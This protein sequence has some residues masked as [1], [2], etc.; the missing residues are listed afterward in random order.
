MKLIRSFSRFSPLLLK[1]GIKFNLQAN[2]YVVPGIALLSYGFLL[3]T[4][5]IFAEEMITVETEDN[6][7]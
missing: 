5:K 2:K 6:I 7:Q 1:N 4:Q 3:G